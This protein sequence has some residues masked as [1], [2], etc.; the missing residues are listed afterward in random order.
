VSNKKVLTL[1][2]VLKGNKILLGMKKRG[3]GSGKWNGFGGKVEN[4]ESLEEGAR[5]ELFEESGLKALKL[6]EVGFNEFSWV[7]NKNPI[8][9]VAIFKTD[10]FIGDPVETEEMSPKWFDIDNVPFKNMWVDDI[11]WFP[12]FISG[13][14]FKGK[15][16]FDENDKILNYSLK[17]V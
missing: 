7:N 16:L 10:S 15:F 4:G 13:K 17:E 1:V 11:Y 12:L 9:E 6:E 3:F 2:L 5:R 8:M 14:K